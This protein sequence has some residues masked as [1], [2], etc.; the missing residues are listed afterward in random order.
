MYA[1]SSASSFAAR[2]GEIAGAISGHPDWILVLALGNPLRGDDGAGQAVL[3]ALSKS[4]R[5]PPDVV[6]VDG[7]T[8]GLDTAL[9]LEGYRQAMILDAAEMG[10]SP[11]EWR[12]L[13]YPGCEA[14]IRPGGAA[15]G[16]HEAGLAEALALA[17]ELGTLP[18]K[19]T[20]FAIQPGEIAWEAGL[21]ES[22]AA[23]VPDVSQ[24]VL[25][26]ILSCGGDGDGKDPDYR[27]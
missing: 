13:E 22:V 14:A 23:S 15:K 18:R 11:G 25:D 2:E 16:V 4:G 10:L 5:L 6:L 24:H 20:L 17:S 26:A 8:A 7:G 9:A 3:E 27:R 19:V 1:S 21:S 12:R